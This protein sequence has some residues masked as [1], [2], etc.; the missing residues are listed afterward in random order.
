MKKKKDRLPPF[1]PTDNHLIDSYIYKKLT[2]ASRV[3]Y[4]LL[5]RQRRRWDQTEVCFPYSDAQEYMDAKTWKRAIRELE[6]S[7][8]VMIK[9]EGGLYRRKNI[10]TIMAYSIRTVEMH[11]VENAKKGQ[12]GVEMHRVN[13]G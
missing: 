7:G 9:Q 1:T 6:Q 13:F 2:N 4:L 8:L 12:T 10:Y 11:R 5:C 3:A